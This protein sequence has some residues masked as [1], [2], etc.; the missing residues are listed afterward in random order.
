MTPPRSG[1]PLNW[2]YLGACAAAVVA[3]TGAGCASAMEA[4]NM[5][6]SCSL[7]WYLQTQL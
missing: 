1:Q 5:R 3:G 7:V 4:R 6:L 2:C